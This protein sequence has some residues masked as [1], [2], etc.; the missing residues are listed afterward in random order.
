M[1]KFTYDMRVAPYMAY[2]NMSWSWLENLFIE[3]DRKIIGFS[4][5]VGPVSSAIFCLRR[6]Y[7]YI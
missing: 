2:F 6:V 5:W 3:A 4:Y 1:S 7:S